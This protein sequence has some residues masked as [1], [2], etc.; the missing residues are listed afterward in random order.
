M[1]PE[2]RYVLDAQLRYVRDHHDETDPPWITEL[3]ERVVDASIGIADVHWSDVVHLLYDREWQQQRLRKLS[4]RVTMPPKGFVRR[5][6][7]RK[8]EGH[9]NRAV[10]TAGRAVAERSWK[11]FSKAARWALSHDELPFRK[12]RTSHESDSERGSGDRG[13]A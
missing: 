4:V 3:K 6:L 1:I 12:S 8:F 2:D 5:T 11:Y 10:M 7:R 13:V 9:P